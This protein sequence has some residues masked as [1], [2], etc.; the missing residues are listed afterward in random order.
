MSRR[1]NRRAWIVL[2]SIAS[3]LVLGCG[4]GNGSNAAGEA[5]P[6]TKAQF[7]QAA[8]RVCEEGLEAKEATLTA[9]YREAEAGNFSASELTQ[10]REE[11]AEGMLSDYQAM[12]ADLSN[13]Q[14]PTSDA[15]KIDALLTKMEA[16][17]T[18]GEADALSLVEGNPF[19]GSDAVAQKYGFKVCGTI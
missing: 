3:M 14:P 11:A 1:G 9:A 8:D 2:G 13:L 6:M 17:I 4:G 10:K 7:I 18:Q 12:T 19:E 5:A 16:A 15:A